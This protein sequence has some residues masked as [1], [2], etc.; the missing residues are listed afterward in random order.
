LLRFALRGGFILGTRSRCEVRAPPIGFSLAAL[1]P[2]VDERVE[3]TL[4]MMWH[5]RI[6]RLNH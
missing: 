4:E 1:P 6:G 3:V 2:Y 5:V